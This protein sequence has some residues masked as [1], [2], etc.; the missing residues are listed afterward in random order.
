MKARR[1]RTA[2]GT[3]KCASSRTT[4][5]QSLSPMIASLIDA[6]LE[7]AQTGSILSWIIQHKKRGSKKARLLSMRRRQRT[8]PETSG[9]SRMMSPCSI[10]RNSSK[11]A[12]CCYYLKCRGPDQQAATFRGIARGFPRHV[13]MRKVSQMKKVFNSVEVNI[14]A[15]FHVFR[16]RN[17]RTVVDSCVEGV[18]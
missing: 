6:R 16:S 17:G 12:P 5:R 10:S 1:K 11:A 7:R 4:T 2:W 13:D 15:T 18:D 3:T 9:L 14:S 8:A